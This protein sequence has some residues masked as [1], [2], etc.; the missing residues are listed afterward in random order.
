MRKILYVIILLVCVLCP[1]KRLDVAKL[2]PVEAV[3]ITVED[4]I[5]RLV[6][7]T[8]SEGEGETAEE[9][10]RALKDN[11]SA[12]IYL[13][14][15]RFLLVGEGAQNAA[16]ELAAYLRANVRIAPYRGTDVKEETRYLDSHKLSSKPWG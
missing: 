9:A 16:Q 10:L 7:D 14:T 6:T 11:S 15:A 4:G 3:A 12:I 13:D 2:E 5:V 1:V 8:Q